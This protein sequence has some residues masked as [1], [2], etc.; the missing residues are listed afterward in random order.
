[1][2]NSLL[3]KKFQLLKQRQLNV[4]RSKRHL[5]VWDMVTRV[6]SNPGYE[7]LQRFPSAVRVLSAWSLS[8]EEHVA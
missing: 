6:A 8:V 4:G 3:D 5:R 2:R 7:M 1:V